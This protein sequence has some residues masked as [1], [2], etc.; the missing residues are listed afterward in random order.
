MV[1]PKQINLGKLIIVKRRGAPLT[2]TF[3]YLMSK[4]DLK[5][6]KAGVSNRENQE[7][8]KKIIFT[9]IIFLQLVG[10]VGCKP[11][12]LPQSDGSIKV[13]AA[14]SFLADIAQNVA[15]DRLMIDVLIPRS[16]D[17][18]SFE[19]TP[20]DVSKIAESQILIVNGAGIEEWLKK[21]LDNAGGSR[22]L[23]EASSGLPSRTPS[24]EE[25]LIEGN[26][27]GQAQIDPHFWMDPTLVIY[28]VENIRAGFTKVDP[29]GSAI[30]KQNAQTYINKLNEL[31][32]W[33]KQQVAVI[34]ENRRLL[35]TNHESLGYFADR[36]GFKVVGAIV[37]SVSS[38]ASPSAQQ[39]ARLIDQIKNTH[40]PAIFLETGV[41]P[42]LANQI[43]SETGTKVV[44][45]I[46]THSIT[47]SGGAA[48]T[49]ID[50]LRYDTNLFVQALR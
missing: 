2:P 24:A 41:T 16:I 14:E 20:N 1:L 9:V 28:Y 33:I 34:P 32:G 11:A 35:V 7:M 3:D 27:E 37:P 31:D 10:M 22:E 5:P 36:Y 6:I 23:I 19:P 8:L 49:F 45:D 15:G 29:A 46:K 40:A 26:G 44:T 21:T 25:L 30:Y 42:Q 4:S 18:H 17:P 12:A 38:N 39:M 13:L 47:E 43:A 48:P 50:M